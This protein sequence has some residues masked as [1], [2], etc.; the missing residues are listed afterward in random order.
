MTLW[1]YYHTPSTVEEALALLDSYQGQAFVVAGGTDL[2]LDIRNKRLPHPE[3]LVDITCVDE[4]KGIHQEGE[5]LI[6]GAGATH[7]EIVHHP[8]IASRAT[9]LVESCGV[10]GGPQVRNVGTLGGNV[11]HALPAADGT[12]SLI[13]LD[14]EAE[15][16]YQGKR[17]WVALKELFRGPGQSLLDHTRD[18]LIRFRF[19]LS[20]AHEASAFK[21]IMRPQ[22]VALPILGCAVW[23]RVNDAGN[24]IEDVRVCI[25]PVTQVPTRATAVETALRGEP[26]TESTFERA[27]TAA[28]E[29]LRPRGSK[30]RATAAYRQEMIDVLL[31]RVLP[32]A[33]ERAQTGEAVPEGVGME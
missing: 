23:M 32:L 3:A 9:C 12:T 10:V 2:L 6:I 5:S 26:V 1:N 18:L 8:L 11:A 20:A 15:I 7:T 25:G 14:A 30:Y 13:V 31:R 16:A 22:G 29:S 4:M 19:P 21:R 28:Q 17:Q 33:A 24:R 27:R